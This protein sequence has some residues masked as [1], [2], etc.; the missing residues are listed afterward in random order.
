MG[1]LERP[2]RVSLAR[3]ASYDPAQV[4][5]ALEACLAPLGG[6]AAH[7]RPGQRVLLKPNFLIAA[8]PEQAVTTHPELILA[9]AEEVLRLGARCDIGD[10]PA[11][12]RARQV[13]R[14]LGLLERAEAM[15]VPVVELAANAVRG[16]ARLSASVAA[17]DAIISLPKLKAHNQLVLTAALKNTFGLVAGKAKAWRHL[18]AGTDP[19]HFCRM[20]LAVHRAAAP[21]LTIVDAVVAMDTRGPRGGRP[22]ALSLIAAGADAA[23]LDTVLCRAVGLTP[24]SVPLLAEATACGFGCTDPAR[25][26]ILGEAPES[27]PRGFRPPGV[28]SEVSFSPLV[29]ARSVL[30]HLWLKL[31]R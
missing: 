6:L 2:A 9:V 5:E 30:R 20:L 27:F 25:I 13:A 11:F 18:R 19:A 26:D 17:Y 1:G 8:S 28:L 16:G 10:S 29:V 7:I 15:G 14:R 4:R 3:C 12:G 22:F 24:D 21:V 31:H 23:A